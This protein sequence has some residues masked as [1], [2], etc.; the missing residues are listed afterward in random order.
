M[1]SMQSSLHSPRT[2][3]SKAYMPTTRWALSA[4]M[5]HLQCTCQPWSA[6]EFMPAVE[7]ADYLRNAGTAATP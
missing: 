1:S 4:C 7:M 5:G 3:T 2:M 6:A